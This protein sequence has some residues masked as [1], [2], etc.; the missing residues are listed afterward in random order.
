[1]SIFFFCKIGEQEGGT[2]PDWGQG[3]CY[4]WNGTGERVWEGEYNTN[5][6]YTCM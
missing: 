3:C 4:Q 6:V 5:T 2:G 1:M